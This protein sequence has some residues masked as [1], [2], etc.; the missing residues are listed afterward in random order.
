[1][2]VLGVVHAHVRGVGKTD[3]TMQVD[4]IVMCFMIDSFM[5]CVC[6]TK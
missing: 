3:K 4:S 2:S 6:L 5:I 1:M